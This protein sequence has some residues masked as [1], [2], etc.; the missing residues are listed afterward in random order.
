M[1]MELLLKTAQGLGGPA[2]IIFALLWW[3]ERRERRQIQNY[4]AKLHRENTARL[5]WLI[6]ASAHASGVPVPIFAESGEDDRLA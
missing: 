3:E 2:A 1:D 6:Q 4:V 5:V